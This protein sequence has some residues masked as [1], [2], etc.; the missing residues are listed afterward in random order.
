MLKCLDVNERKREMD[1][2]LI[3]TPLP[4]I[5]AFVQICGC[6]ETVLIAAQRTFNYLDSCCLNLHMIAEIEP[7]ISFDAN[8]CT[9]RGIITSFATTR[10]LEITSLT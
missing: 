4:V 8:L 9:A 6:R 3:Y 1:S 5:L 2:D 10:H 7:S